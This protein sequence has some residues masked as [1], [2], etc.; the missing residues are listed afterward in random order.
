ML[1]LALPH[2]A[3]ISISA[4]FLSGLH[5]PDKMPDDS[6]LSRLNLAAKESEERRH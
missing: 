6:S 4:I 1:S 5:P 3:T 2:V